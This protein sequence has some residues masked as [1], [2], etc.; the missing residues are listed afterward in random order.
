[1]IPSIQNCAKPTDQEV[2]MR[3]K[4]E[5][6]LHLFCNF[7]RFVILC[8]LLVDAHRLTRH[9]KSRHMKAPALFRKCGKI[10]LRLMNAA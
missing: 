1:M 9:A 6:G 4:S 10:V 7:C 5:G 3:M 8:G 2:Y